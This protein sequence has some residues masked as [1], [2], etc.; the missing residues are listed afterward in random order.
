[1]ACLVPTQD[2]S[3]ENLL[4]GLS[5]LVRNMGGGEIV[6]INLIRD[7]FVIYPGL[8]QQTGRIRL[9]G[10]PGFRHYFVM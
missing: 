5:E 7:Q 4:Y 3:L 1:M 6:L 8:V 10:F 9:L 2:Q